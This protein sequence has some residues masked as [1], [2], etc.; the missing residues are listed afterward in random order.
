MQ[1][2]VTSRGS[3]VAFAA[4]LFAVQSAVPQSP[5]AKARMERAHRAAEKPGRAA[6]DI[7]GALTEQTAGIRPRADAAAPGPIPRRNFIDER[8]FERIE[9]D[10]VPHAPLAGDREFLR[11]AYLDAKIGRALV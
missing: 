6:S 4:L 3:W 2:R 7:A 1:S 11:R 10:G 8:I 9:K 5:E